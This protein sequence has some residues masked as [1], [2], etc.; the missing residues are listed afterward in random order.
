MYVILWE[1]CEQVLPCEQLRR[2]V[3]CKWARV[4][5]RPRHGLWRS[6]ACSRWH[7][8]LALLSRAQLERSVHNANNFQEPHNDVHYK[9]K[10]LNAIRSCDDRSR[11]YIGSSVPYRCSGFRSSAL[12]GCCG[13][14]NVIPCNEIE[15]S[16]SLAKQLKSTDLQQLICSNP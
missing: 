4:L 15:H 10:H 14:C 7:R 5:V 11:S 2:R 1:H 12:R 8:K 13:I 6:R 9:S 16:T 3:E